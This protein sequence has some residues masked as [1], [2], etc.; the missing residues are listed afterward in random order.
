MKYNRSRPGFELVSPC[1]F[2]TTITITPR[3]SVPIIISQSPF[4]FLSLS[5]SIYIYIYIYIYHHEHYYVMLW[6]WI[7]LT[8]SLHPSLSFIAPRSSNLHPISRIY[9]MQ[10]SYCRSTNTATS[11]CDIYTSEFESH[12]VPHSYGFVP[13]LSKK[14]SKLPHPYVTS[15]VTCEFLLLHQQCPACFVRL[16]WMCFGDWR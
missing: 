4:L 16:T 7:S 15:T 13:H 10:I 5:L 6:A 2:P 12:W 3:A 11:I 8:L 9:L 14:L 1:P